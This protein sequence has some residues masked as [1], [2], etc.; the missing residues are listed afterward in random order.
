MAFAHMLTTDRT[1]RVF[2][3][4]LVRLLFKQTNLKCE[5]IKMGFPQGSFQGNILEYFTEE[6]LGSV[7]K[8]E[9]TI[10]NFRSVFRKH[11]TKTALIQRKTAAPTGTISAE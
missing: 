6:Q 2:F 3:I 7:S 4:E 9:T 11:D 1:Q 8:F 5:A 10:V